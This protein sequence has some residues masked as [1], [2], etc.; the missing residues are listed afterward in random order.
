MQLEIRSLPQQVDMAIPALEGFR[1][2]IGA[3]IVETS[4][5]IVV[6]DP[7]PYKT[8][9]ILVHELETRG[10]K[11]L[12]AILLT[13]IH[14]DHAG[15]TAALLERFSGTPVVAHSRVHKH[16]TDPRELISGSMKVL[17]E[18]LMSGY[19]PILPISAD[20]LV[21][22]ETSNWGAIPTPGHSSDHVSYAIGDTIFTGEALG[23]TTPDA[24]GFYL[25]PATPPRFFFDTY[26]S[27]IRVLDEKIKEQRIS[28]YCFG[29]FGIR[30]E[31]ENQPCR[32]PQMSLA[33]IGLWVETV[34]ADPEA[35]IERIVE[36]LLKV[37][38]YFAPFQTL[39]AD[40]QAREMIFVTNSIRGILSAV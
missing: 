5:G 38:P 18:S 16:L 40:I 36:C 9:P 2:F 31:N 37:D 19:G 21:P 14:I 17:G 7:G 33:Q 30:E 20:L 1:S 24:L 6:V 39:P 12:A 26:I 25:R 29:H 10:V 35:P 11:D 8:I 15:G 22:A 34:R 28:R 4:L 32:L 23:N 13:H 27:S 3:W